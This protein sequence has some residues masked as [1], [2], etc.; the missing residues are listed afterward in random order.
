M[1]CL[2]EKIIKEKLEKYNLPSFD[3]ISQKS[4]ERLINVERCIQNKI[5]VQLDMVKKLKE[6]KITKVSLGKEV[7]IARKTLYNDE[8]LRIYIDRSIE[9]EKDI[10]NV[11]KIEKLEKQIEEL[12]KRYDDVINNIIEINLL[13]IKIKTYA[14][15]LKGLFHQ[16]EVLHSII[17][18][19]DEMIIR[20]QANKNNVI[21]ISR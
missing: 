15:E 6:T 16:N 11:I 17:C 12:T 7:S 10:F 9:E 1:D 5:E 4:M 3:N 18:E 2:I 13:K 21:N 20:L 8:I 14:S 19:K